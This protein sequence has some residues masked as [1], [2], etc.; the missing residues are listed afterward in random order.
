METEMTTKHT[1]IDSKGQ[2]HKRS[3]KDRIY[4][5]AIVSHWEGGR[6]RVSWAGSLALAQKQL[7][8]NDRYQGFISA[9][10][11]EAV[12]TLA[13]GR[14]GYVLHDRAGTALLCLKG[15]GG[16]CVPVEVA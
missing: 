16:L 15:Q 3:S 13:D 7:H 6:T 4:T 11:I 2:T 8:V 5:H 1:A 12:V 14:Q 10:I 9:E